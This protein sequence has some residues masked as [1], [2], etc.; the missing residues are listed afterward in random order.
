MTTPQAPDPLDA[1]RAR[2]PALVQE[3]PDLHAFVDAI[4]D[5]VA[6]LVHRSDAV[7]ADPATLH[8]GLA[9]LLAEHGIPQRTLRTALRGLDTLS[10]R[11][12]L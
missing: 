2:L 5:E 4:L 8:R 9:M 11:P 10:T 1:L 7:R 3:H 6:V 12:R